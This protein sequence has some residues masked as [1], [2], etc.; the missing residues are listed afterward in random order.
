MIYLRLIRERGG[1]W[2]LSL[3]RANGFGYY[4]DYIIAFGD[5]V[6]DGPLTLRKLWLVKNREIVL[7]N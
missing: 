3:E 5:V 7:A 4:K 6:G 1:A 2:N